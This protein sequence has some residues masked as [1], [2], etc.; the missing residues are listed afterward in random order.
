MTSKL[1]FFFLV[2]SCLTGHA[3]TLTGRVI[4]A[5]TKAPLETVSI[6][7]DN[8]TIGTT[9]NQNGEFSIDYNDAVQSTL[10]ISFLGFESVFISDYR[11]LSD[12]KVELKEAINE[13]DEVIIDAD[14][15]MSRAKKL[16]WFRKEFLGRSEFGK[17]CKILNETD[18]RFRYNKRNRTLI[19]WSKKPILVKNKGLQYEI[20][21]DIVDFEIIIGNWNA[22]SVIYS[23]TTFFKDLD[24]KGKRK[25]LKNRASAY[26]GSVQH[27]M[28][29]LYTKN[30]EKEGYI[31]GVRGFLVMPFDFFSI[32]KANDIGVKTVSLKKKLDI[33]YE[34][35]S[36]SIIQTTGDSF[37]V[38]QFGNYEA[39]PNVLFGGYMGSQRIGDTLPLDYGLLKK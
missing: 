32:S 33:F 38:D 18:L 16:K 11:N 5:A 34:D 14:D 9:T 27:F 37:M 31:F 24:P 26:K 2:F 13:L 28:R 36:E 30:F 29:A 4:D 23:G 25:T 7:F 6:Y 22:K 17:S 39:I 35:G 12:I 15:G 3:Q 20:S 19:A 8:T 21:F 10:V 1:T